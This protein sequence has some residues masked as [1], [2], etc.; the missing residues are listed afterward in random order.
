[1]QIWNFSSYLLSYWKGEVLFSTPYLNRRWQAND[2]TCTDADNPV[3]PTDHSDDEEEEDEDFD[4]SAGAQ[5]AAWLG[6]EEEV[7]YAKKD[8]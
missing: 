1:M 5:L 2:R 3:A 7:S 8:K 6:G 4:D